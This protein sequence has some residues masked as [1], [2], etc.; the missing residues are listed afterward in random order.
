MLLALFAIDLGSRLPL[1]PSME[2]CDYTFSSLLSYRTYVHRHK[3]TDDTGKTGQKQRDTAQQL[4]NTIVHTWSIGYPRTP[5]SGK[6]ETHHTDVQSVWP[7][8]L[9]MPTSCL[10]TL[11]RAWYYSLWRVPKKWRPDREVKITL[12]TQTS[13]L[14]GRA[15]SEGRRHIPQLSGGYA[16]LPAGGCPKRGD[17]TV[18][19][20]AHPPHRYPVGLDGEPTL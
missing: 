3:E 16:I 11:W 9:G 17:P 12:T 15:P 8:T 7:R 20:N 18:W 6:Y 10:K 13:S 14:F 19:S 2:L 5:S 1:P 4:K